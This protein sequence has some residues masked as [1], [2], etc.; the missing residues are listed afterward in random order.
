[1]TNKS[2]HPLVKKFREGAM[3]CNDWRD[4]IF[5]TATLAGLAAVPHLHLG[6]KGLEGVILTLPA[7]RETVMRH[8][9]WWPN[10][11]Y[12]ASAFA[13]GTT[14]GIGALLTNACMQN[15]QLQTLCDPA[16]AGMIG[17][18]TLVSSG[19]CFIAG[20]PKAIYRAYKDT[21][22]DHPR[23]MK[24]PKQRRK[25]K[26]SQ[27]VRDLV[28]KMKDGVRGLGGPVPQPAG[29]LAGAVLRHFNKQAPVAV[30]NLG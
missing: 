25:K 12:Q 14:V 5:Y 21:M 6:Y 4:T 18:L 28:E 19:T 1:M 23:K 24:P 8:L 13:M 20:G 10:L 11:R 3:V 9:S 15:H 22:W 17:C 27:A 29:R 2:D 30:S 26:L 16:F 7:C